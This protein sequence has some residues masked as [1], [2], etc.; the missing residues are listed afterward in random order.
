MEIIWE[1]VT[2]NLA[3]RVT[4]FDNLTMQIQ[5][6]GV[7]SRS[8]VAYAYYN[9]LSSLQYQLSKPWN[10]TVILTPCFCIKQSVAFC[11]RK[12]H[13]SYT[14]KW[15]LMHDTYVKSKEMILACISAGVSGF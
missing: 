7:V 3:G 2:N 8:V 13:E 14:L 6:R 10:M 9:Y 4:L 5:T 1:L 12:P 15:V 11:F